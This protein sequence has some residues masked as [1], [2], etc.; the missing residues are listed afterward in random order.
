MEG[1]A[2]LQDSVSGKQITIRSFDCSAESSRC[3]G[4]RLLS[5]FG[6]LAF[7]SLSSVL[8]GGSARPSQSMNQLSAGGPTC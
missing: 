4:P 5:G 6:I 3:A 8:E 2:E 1:E 7:G